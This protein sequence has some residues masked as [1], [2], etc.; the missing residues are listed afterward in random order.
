MVIYDLICAMDHTFEGWFKS[1]EDYNHQLNHNML[2]CPLCESKD[3][4]KLPSA[5]Y[6]SAKKTEQK[7]ISKSV[8][9]EAIEVVNKITNFIIENTEDVGNQF[10][11]EAKKIHYGE[12]EDRGIRG[13]ATSEELKE[14]NEEGIAVLSIPGHVR[15]KS[16]LN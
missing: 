13:Q 2:S 3:I 5:S 16:K 1:I 6:I 14:L 15:D 7:E 12:S 9:N 4:R 8:T 11:T 10:A